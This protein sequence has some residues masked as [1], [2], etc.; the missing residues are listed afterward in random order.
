LN[1]TRI[2]QDSSDCY[3]IHRLTS[4]PKYSHFRKHCV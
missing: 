1:R 2:K 4:R 3:C